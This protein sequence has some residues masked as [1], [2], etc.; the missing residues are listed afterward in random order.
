MAQSLGN[1]PERPVESVAARIPRLPETEHLLQEN[2][3]STV[4]I[5]L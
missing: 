5:H 4:N 3:E 1:F 2:C